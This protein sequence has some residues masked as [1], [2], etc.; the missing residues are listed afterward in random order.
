MLN[1]RGSGGRRRL[2]LLLAPL[3]ALFCLIFAAPAAFAAPGDNGDVKVHA[4]TT[5]VTDQRDDTHV[6]EFY[7]DAFNFDTVQ[8]VSWSISQQPPTGRAQVL[9]GSLTLTDGTGHT[10]EMTLPAGH[11]KLTWTFAGEKGRAKSK[12]FWSTCAATPSPSPSQTVV[13][14]P[15]PSP[16]QTMVNSP[17]PSPS[18]CPACHSPTPSPTMP[19][20]S[21][22]A[23]ASASGSTAVSPSTGA[24]GGP[25]SGGGKLAETGSPLLPLAGGTAL[26]VA[27]G[28]LLS[29]RSRKSAHTR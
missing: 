15:S 29:R 28:A 21:A 17:S 7:L 9:S 18:H 24:S 26:L 8:Q 16:S 19:T 22:S 14:S 5:P 25:G 2:P 13:N 12:V 27:A 3:V 23:T 6:C 11:Y 1:S 4:S 10:A 20:G